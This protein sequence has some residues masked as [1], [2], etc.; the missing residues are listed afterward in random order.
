MDKYVNWAQS[1]GV[2]S[3]Y[4][5]EKKRCYKGEVLSS[6]VD[7][8]RVGHACGGIWVQVNRGDGDGGGVREGVM[9]ERVT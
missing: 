2:A 9:R 1:R 6:R 7:G 5:D 4:R 8:L 3:L